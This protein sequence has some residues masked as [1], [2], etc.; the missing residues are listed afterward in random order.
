MTRSSTMYSA[1][2]D[3]YDTVVLSWSGAARAATVYV[4]SLPLSSHIPVTVL[5]IG[6]G[7][8]LYTFAAL[9]RFPN[10][11]VWAFDSNKAMVH[12]L[13]R[14]LREA[15]VFHR[16]H[17][18]V[19]DMSQ[20]L[21]IPSGMKFDC[22]IASGVLEY[23]HLPTILN[24]LIPYLKE[25]GYFFDAAIQNTLAGRLLAVF[26]GCKPSS[27]QEIADAF[28]RVGCSRLPMNQLPSSYVFLR[29]IKE[30]YLFQKR[31]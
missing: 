9:K 3:Y 18:S 2:A 23:G 1:L 20:D 10:A 16:V 28:Q 30:G 15:G 21:P 8:G 31:S 12:T 14:K 7:T 25:G 24:G 27:S 17:L 22:M 4:S 5:D 29:H 11:T 6:C 26:W 13:E 19:A